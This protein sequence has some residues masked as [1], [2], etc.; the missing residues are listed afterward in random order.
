MS[1]QHDHN[2]N[3]SPQNADALTEEIADKAKLLLKETLDVFAEQ[4]QNLTE[5]LQRFNARQKQ[6]EEKIKSGGY[7]TSGRIV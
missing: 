6:A 1:E 3:I 4:N 5:S 2:Q 7:R